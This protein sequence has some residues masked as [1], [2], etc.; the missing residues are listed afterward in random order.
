MLLSAGAS[1]LHVTLYAYTVGASVCSVHMPYS[2]LL[3]VHVE[4]FHPK[5]RHCGI[6]VNIFAVVPVNSGN[7]E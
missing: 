6:C 5:L 7:V 4:T 1:V 3:F 2:S